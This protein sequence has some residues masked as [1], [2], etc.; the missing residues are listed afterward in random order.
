MVPCVRRPPFAAPTSHLQLVRVGRA[1]GLATRVHRRPNA[2]RTQLRQRARQGYVFGTARRHCASRRP[3]A[4]RPLLR[5]R[6]LRGAVCG[7]LPQLPGCACFHQIAPRSR[8]LQHVLRWD[9]NGTR[10]PGSANFRQIAARSSL[11]RRVLGTGHARGIRVRT[12]ASLLR[13]PAVR[14]SPNRH[15]PRGLAFGT[16]PSVMQ[17]KMPAQLPGR[18]CERCPPDTQ[19]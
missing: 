9:A 18:I 10:A 4:P 1:A 7:I 11:N 3:I 19:T 13:R 16:G 5:Q 14:L 17:L 15:A 6:A 8:V 2:P 12:S